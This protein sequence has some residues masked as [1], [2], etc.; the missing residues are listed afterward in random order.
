MSQLE[1]KDNKDKIILNELLRKANDGLFMS[2]EEE[3][4]LGRVIYDSNPWNYP[5]EPG[6]NVY[7]D[8]NEYPPVTEIQ[9]KNAMLAKTILATANKLL[10]LKQAC[11]YHDLMKGHVPLDEIQMNGFKGMAIGLNKYDYRMGFKFGSY[12]TWFV[13]RDCH[14]DSQG[15]SR[16]V[17]VPPNDIKRFAAVK[18]KIEDGADLKDALNEYGMTIEDYNR[19]VNADKSHA[20]LDTKVMGSDHN[21]ATLL[22][23]CQE[24]SYESTISRQ[25]S[26]DEI[27]ENE[28]IMR[29][30][31][32]SIAKLPQHQRDL[33]SALY[34]PDRDTIG[35]NGKMKTLSDSRC[36]RELG[37]SREDYNKTKKAALENLR[38]LMAGWKDVIEY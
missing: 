33:I 16:I 4:F 31:A 23:V 25:P 21:E 12:L 35:K 22:D 3:L 19:I 5:V 24:D 29:D 37:W 34:A 20:S 6:G 11:K 17:E 2:K 32:L 38:T 18:K 14:R 10:V 27:M 36:R 30:L 26:I 7:K 28:A 15:L 9:K 1:V 8:E 13:Y